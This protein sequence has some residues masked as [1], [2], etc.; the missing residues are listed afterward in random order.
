MMFVLVQ[1]KREILR[2]LHMVSEKN[3]EKTTD[4][5]IMQTELTRPKVHIFLSN[6]I[7]LRGWIN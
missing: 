2:Y 7:I 3:A 4:I 6:C 1:I 5:V